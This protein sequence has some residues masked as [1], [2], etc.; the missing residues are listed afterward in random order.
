VSQEHRRDGEG[1]LEVAVAP[2]D[3]GLVLVAVQDFG[4]VDVGGEVAQQG[5][6]AVTGGVG[7]DR[8]LVEGWSVPDLV[9]TR[10]CGL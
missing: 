5:V 8:G 1:A 3:G 9:D 2:L 4:G 10:L 6:P 7:V